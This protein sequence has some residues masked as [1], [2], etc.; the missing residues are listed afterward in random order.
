MTV[1][2]MRPSLTLSL[3]SA[4]GVLAAKDASSVAA[5]TKEGKNA[6]CKE[7][8]RGDQCAFACTLRNIRAECDDP[9]A[10]KQ[11]RKVSPLLMNRPRDSAAGEPVCQWCAEVE[12]RAPCEES[13]FVDFWQGAVGVAAV[14]RCEWTVPCEPGERPPCNALPVCRAAEA[15]VNCGPS[16]HLHKP[17]PPPLSSPPPPPPSPPLPRPPPPQPPPPPIPPLVLFEPTRAG[18]ATLML[19]QAPQPQPLQLQQTAVA[20]ATAPVMTTRAA[21]AGQGSWRPAA[22][23]YGGGAWSQQQGG[24]GWE[25]QPQPQQAWAGDHAIGDAT[26]GAA[27]ISDFEARMVRGGKLLADA[28]GVALGPDLSAFVSIGAAAATFCCCLCL[29]WA[30]CCT[31]RAQGGKAGGRSVRPAG[32]PRRKGYQKAAGAAEPEATD[33]SESNAGDDDDDDDEQPNVL[34]AKYVFHAC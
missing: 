20:G 1:C 2:S 27:I 16:P 21:A 15:S 4:M 29:Y 7:D 24:A 9:D 31:R 30:C 6:A 13:F 33:E 32:K 14:R 3:L 5:A 10:M 11:A 19:P 28:T 26:D 17:S 34:D 23:P 12:S 25:G 18:P 8:A 22:D